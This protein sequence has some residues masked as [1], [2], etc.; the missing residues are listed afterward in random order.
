M[1]FCICLFDQCTEQKKNS[2]MDIIELSNGE[3]IRCKSLTKDEYQLLLKDNKREAI[4]RF[5]DRYGIEVRNIKGNSVV[6]KEQDYY[7]LYFSIEDLDKVLLDATGALG[8]KELLLNKNLYGQKF[9]EKTDSLIKQL[10]L[11]L[12]IQYVPLDEKLLKEIDKA[13]LVLPNPHLFKE[14]YFLNFIAIVGET[15]IRKHNIS[16][17]MEMAADRMTWNPYLIIRNQRVQFF[18]YLYEDVFLK[19]NSSTNSP[20]LSEIF[21]TV[22]DIIQYNIR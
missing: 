12:Q 15:L 5:L 2:P 18:V 6:V 16:W 22:E 3:S 11:K 13:I 4:Q 14:E 17:Q 21:E 20:F 19:E 10:L 1:I 9:P 8:G 7:T